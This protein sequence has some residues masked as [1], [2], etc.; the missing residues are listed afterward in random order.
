MSKLQIAHIRPAVQRHSLQ[1]VGKTV[2]FNS[3]T[4]VFLYLQ[5]IQR[6]ENMPLLL[7][8]KYMNMITRHHLFICVSLLSLIFVGCD[9]GGGGGGGGG[10]DINRA[11]WNKM[12]LPMEFGA[13]VDL[14][15]KPTV[16]TETP[17]YVL[18]EHAWVDSDGDRL[19]AV[20]ANNLVYHAEVVLIEGNTIFSD[21][22]DPCKDDRNSAACQE[23]IALRVDPITAEIIAENP[24][25][26][27]L[28]RL[29]P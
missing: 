14:L 7:R 22:K 3:W 29:D 19:L 1:M 25:F 2:P 20:A 10:T 8:R 15:G 16:S 4:A 27:S 28:D 21:Y 26:K 17:N 13:L 12:T 6:H 9:M 11:K 18:R 5:L 24:L 23:W